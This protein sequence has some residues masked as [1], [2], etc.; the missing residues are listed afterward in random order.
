WYLLDATKALKPFIYQER[1]EA[2]FA[3]LTDINNEHVFM[4]DEAVFG[5]KVRD[6]AGLGFWQM[7]NKSTVEFNPENFAKAYTDMKTVRGDYDK[8]LIL[9]P[10]ILL[11]PDTL[12]DA[13]KELMTAE[14]IDGKN[15]LHRNKCEV[16][17][18]PWL[19]N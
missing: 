2:N 16:M 17:V 15:N 12:E 9:K 14:K 1:Q 18:C 6:A 8:K 19:S 11:V 13:A 10:S 7:A 4:K 5:A 3:A